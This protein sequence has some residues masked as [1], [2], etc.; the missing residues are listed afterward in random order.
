MKPTR[1]RT[2][3]P[4]RFTPRAARAAAAERLAASQANPVG[5]DSALQAAV[6]RLYHLSSQV[7]G[8]ILESFPLV[9]ERDRARALQRLKLHE[10]DA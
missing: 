8:R 1:Q 9:P 2:R 3:L 5:D 10:G 6:A 4:A 7:F